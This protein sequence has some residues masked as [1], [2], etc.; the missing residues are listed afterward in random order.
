[1][2]SSK[3]GKSDCFSRVTKTLVF[4]FILRRFVRILRRKW[5]IKITWANCS[6]TEFRD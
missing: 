3:C 4:V 1:M 6:S 5:V 2:I